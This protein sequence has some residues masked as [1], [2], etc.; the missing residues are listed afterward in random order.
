[1]SKRFYVTTA[2]DYVNGE[3]HLGHAYEKILAD[4]LA[5]SRR[6]LGL[7]AFYLTGLDEHG[8]KV[9]QAAQARGKSPQA[10]CDE[11][12][13]TWKSLATKLE[14]SNDDF[15]RTTEPRHQQVVQAI[16]TKLYASGHFYKDTYRGFYSTKEETFL[17]EKDRLPDGT[18]PPQ[19][20][21]VIELVEDNYYFKLKDQQQWLIDYIEQ[22][23]GFI[24]PDT[25][26]N[27]MLGFLKNNTLED[28]C[29]TRPAERLTWGIPVPFDKNYVTYVWFDAL[30]NYISIPAAHGDPT[31]LAAVGSQPSTTNPQLP[32]WPADAHVIGKDILKFHAVYWPI[33]LKAM[34]LPLPKQ[35]LV[36]GWWQ[37]DGEKLSKTTGN[38]VDPIAVVDEWG[39]D[40]F[41]YYV[42]RELAIGPDGNWTNAGFEM[43]YESE[44]AKK[45]GNLLNRSLS[46]LNRYRAGVVPARSD[47][48]SAEAGKVTAET[49][50]LL[51]ESQ[52]QAALMSIWTLVGHANKYIDDTAPFKL[53]KDPA[54]AKRLDEVLYN[55]VET[56][57]ILAVLLWPFLPGTAV[58]MYRQL[59]LDGTPDKFGETAWGGLKAGQKIGE[60]T[61]LFPIKEKPKT[62]DAGK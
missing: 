52:L 36:H 26:R 25:R 17:T 32:L 24:Q 45:L 16:L 44:L 48:L 41:R 61:P 8:Q 2:I 7:D 57:R 59:G 37:K 11:L 39:L 6:S 60:V 21:E 47:E 3:P 10:Y 56:C 13:L 50:A 42:V 43:R 28:L 9:Q 49:R 58:K 51:E 14:L 23:P 29:C 35:I 20:G 62:P 19:Y 31:V 55:L 46:M 30:V 33:M 1:M 34:G 12:S 15:V 4:V 38:V 18:F 40:A 5:R 54:Q 22:N 27:E 53:A